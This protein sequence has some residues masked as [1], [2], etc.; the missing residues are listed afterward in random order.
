MHLISYEPKLDHRSLYHKRPALTRVDSLPYVFRKLRIHRNLTISSLANK[1][2]FSEDYVRAIES[3]SKFPSLKFCLLCAQEFGANPNWVKSKWAND[4][5]EQFS[6][7]LLKRLG[8]D[9]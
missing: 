5:I 9:Q 2:G 1:F 4:R 7:R 3:G 8:L 6:Q